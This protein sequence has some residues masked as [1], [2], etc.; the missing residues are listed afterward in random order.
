MGPEVGIVVE[1]APSSSAVCQL[2]MGYNPPNK[3]GKRKNLVGGFNPF[4]KY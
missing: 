1:F 4:E 2:W 3:T